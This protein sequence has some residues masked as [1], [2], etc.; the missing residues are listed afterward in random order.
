MLGLVV[1]G[2]VFLSCETFTPAL[3]PAIKASLCLRSA[4]I[5]LS[6]G[7]SNAAWFSWAAIKP[8]VLAKRPIALA[9][10]SW[11]VVASIARLLS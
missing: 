8:G 7:P 6:M 10:M 1:G 9:C 5:S 4:A 11:L 2:G 3:P